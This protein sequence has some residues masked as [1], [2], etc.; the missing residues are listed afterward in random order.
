MRKSD[1]TSAMEPSRDHESTPEILR[2]RGGPS[3]YSRS[4]YSRV[5]VAEDDLDHTNSQTPQ[6]LSSPPVVPAVSEITGL[7]TFGLGITDS[8]GQILESPVEYGFA[9]SSSDPFSDPESTP[10][11]RPDLGV[12]Y[13]SYATPIAGGDPEGLRSP[14]T[15][16]NTPRGN[17]IPSPWSIIL[18]VM[19]QANV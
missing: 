5:A 17:P 16:M 9:R 19:T 18:Y 3:I 7:P 13:S 1:H 8:Q 12:R 2:P 14:P 11:S 15:T 10:R 6:R 4:P